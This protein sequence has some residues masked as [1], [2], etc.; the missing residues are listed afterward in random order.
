VRYEDNNAIFLV[1]VA[2]G[3]RVGLHV[4]RRI[5]RALKSKPL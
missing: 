1:H 5:M 3:K 2:P 4:G